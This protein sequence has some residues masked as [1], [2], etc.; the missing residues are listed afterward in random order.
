M[1]LDMHKF[2]RL[3]AFLAVAGVSAS[4]HAQS[5]EYRRGYEDGY[6]AGQRAAHD[7]RGQGRGWGRVRIEE[8]EYG[9]RGAMCD[10]REG[11]RR[12]VER[13]DGA[14]RVDNNLCGDPAP[15]QRKRLRVVYRCRDT[16]PARAFATEGETLKLTCR[17]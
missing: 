11:V 17:R 7:D 1:A 15:H 13:N 6:A 2:M 3:A 5:A 8:A 4:A 16:E 12:E 14:I 9:I 10:A